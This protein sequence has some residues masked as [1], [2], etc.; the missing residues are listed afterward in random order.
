MPSHFRSEEM[1]LCQLY[2]QNEAAYSCVSELG[3]LGLAQFRDLNL[4]FNYFQRKFANEILRCNEMERKLRFLEVEVMKDGVPIVDD[5]E[6]PEA[7]A[8]CEIRGLEDVLDKM[9]TE[10]KVVNR[11]DNALNRNRI[12][13]M[14]LK[15]VLQR[16]QVFFDEVSFFG[17]LK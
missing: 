14:E 12:E 15:S 16:I 17:I 5:G 11:Y 13:L 2:I 4:D 1:A 10:L 6:D 8:E 3:E 7:P 9:E